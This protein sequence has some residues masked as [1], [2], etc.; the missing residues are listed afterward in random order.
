VTLRSYKSLHSALFFSV[1][2][3]VTPYALR[4]FKLFVHG[5]ILVPVWNELAEQVHG[6]YQNNNTIV[7]QMD[8]TKNSLLPGMCNA[9]VEGYPT[10]YLFRK[11]GKHLPVEYRGPRDLQSLTRFLAAHP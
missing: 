5:L 3:H 10:I 11:G 1:F 7:A 8:M 9:T 4:C 2:C 6:S